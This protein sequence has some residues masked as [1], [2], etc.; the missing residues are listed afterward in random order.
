MRKITVN[1]GFGEEFTMKVSDANY[2]NGFFYI[3]IHKVTYSTMEEDPEEPQ[4]KRL[5]FRRE[6]SGE[7]V[8]IGYED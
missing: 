1:L 5:L 2:K 6:A 8:L 3:P 4:T 7:F